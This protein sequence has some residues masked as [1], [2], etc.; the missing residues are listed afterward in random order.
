MEIKDWINVAAILLSPAFAVTITLW[1]Q[2]RADKRNVKEDIFFILMENRSSLHIAQETVQALNSIDFA[3][4]DD[5]RVIN[6]WS[7]YYDSLSPVN[8]D[9]IK[10]NRLYIELLSIIALHLG[11]KKLTQMQID[12]FYT[13]QMHIDQVENFNKINKEF[14]RVLEAS[15][16]FGTQSLR[17]E[18]SIRSKSN[19]TTK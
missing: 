2:R 15:D 6:I 10:S 12:K 9:P 5:Q 7:A 18:K 8:H 16:S 1:Y 4:Q 14:S 11:Y 19:R 3:F 17:K 13:P